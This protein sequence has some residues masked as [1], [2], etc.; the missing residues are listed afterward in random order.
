MSDVTLGTAQLRRR[1]LRH[2]FQR[3]LWRNSAPRIAQD[4]LVGADVG[5]LRAWF[6]DAWALRDLG[7]V[8]RIGEALKARGWLRTT[9]AGRLRY[10]LTDLGR[11]QAA[12]AIAPQ[13]GA[14]P[15]DLMALADVGR[16][17]EARAR[18]AEMDPGADPETIALLGRA[19]SEAAP[20]AWNPQTG[21]VVA[22]L[23]LHC[24]DL[25]ADLAAQALRRTVPQG[26]ELVVALHLLECC[27]RMASP[28]AALRLLEAI[29]P[30]FGP[31]DRA[32]YEAVRRLPEGGP[33]DGEAMVA[34]AGEEPRFTLAIVLA[35]ACGAVGRA[36]AA[37]RRLCG[38]NALD[39]QEAGHLF[40]LAR[41]V[42][43]AERLTPSYVQPAGPRRIFDV[44]P[45]NGEF[46]LLD[47][48]LQTMGDWVD[49]F[50]LVEANRTFTDN[51]KPLYFRDAK[52]RY[53]AWAGKIVHVVVDS[54]PAFIRSAWA[55][56][57]HQ[58]D[59]GVRGLSGLCAP[60]DLVLISDVDEIV[61]PAALEG[62]QEP[63]ASIGMRSFQLFLNYERVADRGRKFKVGVVQA[64]M[65]Q[66]AGL[67]G[68][69]VGMWAYSKRRLRNG[70]WH[71]SSLLS[72]ED[73]ELKL[74]SYSHEEHQP[75]AD[76]AA[77]RRV[78]EQIRGGYR[79]P[80]FACVPIDESFPRALSER[81]EA[82]A[83]FILPQDGS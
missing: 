80:G 60:E 62:F 26:D 6:G 81:P 51:P 10:V 1:A 29:G 52:D 44:F 39:L 45:F 40:E 54:E 5:R 34:G 33:D 78:R 57:Y 63:F 8:E 23:E 42:G 71:F 79:Q 58:R 4:R 48:K 14:A 50:V 49:G 66:A 74:H 56:E 32:A 35:Q 76:A 47:L 53:A 28:P 43:A 13:S 83:G 12:L 36:D 18:L 65:L 19:L 31:A 67:S 27:F 68:L 2:V 7:E 22:A 72:P 30:L 61:D 75:G 3:D 73:I 11:P 46:G 9:D 24:G 64:R 55:R 70:G 41:L 16:V 69:R 77:V 37:V 38:F 21:Q 20:E 17:G 82:Y 15:W 25:A 59:Q